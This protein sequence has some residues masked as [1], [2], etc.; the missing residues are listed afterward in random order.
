MIGRRRR[1]RAERDQKW[2]QV[3]RDTTRMRL[4]LIYATYGEPVVRTI[5]VRELAAL[6]PVGM[7]TGDETP[8]P[9]KWAYRE[10]EPVHTRGGFSVYPI[11]SEWFSVYRTGD[12]EGRPF[13]TT[14]RELAQLVCNQWS[15]ELREFV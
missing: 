12:A 14:D 13:T 11:D 15:A 1:E 4:E 3:V 6:P 10:V 5:R 2:A 8:A 9:P 7:W